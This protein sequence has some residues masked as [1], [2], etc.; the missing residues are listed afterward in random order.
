MASI[1]LFDTGNHKN[2]LLEDFSA[3]SRCRPTST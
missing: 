1:N 2:V 3:A